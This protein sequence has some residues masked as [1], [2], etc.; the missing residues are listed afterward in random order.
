M[1]V[2]IGCLFTAAGLLAPPASGEQ[3]CVRSGPTCTKRDA[4]GCCVGEAP[5]KSRRRR[6]ESMSAKCPPGQAPIAGHC[7][8]P[9]QDWG[10]NSGKCLGT[11]Q[12]PA[13]FVL[14]DAECEPGCPPG[15]AL[16]AGHC[17][18]PGQD[19]GSSKN[20]CLGEPRCPSGWLPDGTSGCRQGPEA[21]GEW[22]RI[23]SGRF[24]MGS[25]DDELDRNE[26]ELQHGVELTRDYWMQATEVSQ[27]QFEE[28]MGYNPSRFTECGP[29][30]P[31]ERVSWHE[32]AAYCNALSKRG[33]APQCYT[34]KGRGGGVRCQSS[35][36][37]SSSYACPGYRLPTEAEWEYAARAGTRTALYSGS[38]TF[39]GE[40]NA[41][42]LDLIAWY[43]G[44]S[45]VRYRGGHDCSEWPERQRPANFCGPHPVGQKLPNEWGLYDM[46]G[47][48]WEWCDDGYGEY[49]SGYVTDPVGSSAGSIR[50]LR[51][52]S[53]SYDASYTRIALRD[54][55]GPDSRDHHVGFR[56]VRALP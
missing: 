28:I 18:W 49:P 30:C 27:G 55:F 25:P 36:R 19:W 13:G 53:W 56:V 1:A 5:S 9:G 29:N 51:G 34:C 41:P 10:V 42:A 54:L 35:S 38:V 33:A 2:V 43:G 40:N 6:R 8:W 23:R 22:L 24:I 20:T 21:P 32:S 37:W 17:C 31:V 45:G 11:P 4:R 7:C 15:K 26:N 14:R 47:N 3:A 12:C 44:N 52:G 16:I 48:V 39:V 50:V 46:L